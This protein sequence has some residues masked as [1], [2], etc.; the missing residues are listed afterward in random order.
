M[1]RQTPLAAALL[2][3]LRRDLGLVW[4]RR[5]DAAQPL[6]FALMVIA[7]FPLAL[8]S[9]PAR[10]AAIAPAVIWVASLLNATDS[11]WFV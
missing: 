7:L 6:L 9:E 4:R 2:A 5:G 8:G 1:T 3:Q 11:T 10:L